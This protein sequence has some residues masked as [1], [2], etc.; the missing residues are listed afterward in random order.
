MVG[1]CRDGE[2][3]MGVPAGNTRVFVLDEWLAPVPPGMAGELYVA[4]HGLARGYAGRA[5]LT[6]ERFVACPFGSGERMYRTGDRARWTT[7]GQLVFAGRADDQVQIRGFRVEPGEVEAGLRACPE[8][9]RAV[10]VARED[11]PGVRH[12]VGYVVPEPGAAVDGPG[13][14]EQV[15]GRLPEYM[16]PGRGGGA[17]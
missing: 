6:G 5:G 15:A 14:R 9:A 3:V 8:V 17:G 16:V 12:L 2:V 4:G 10:V 1:E 7:G 13:L 11:R